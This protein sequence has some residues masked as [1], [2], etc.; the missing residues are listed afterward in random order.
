MDN[1]KIYLEI[2]HKFSFKNMNYLRND[3]ICGC[4]YCLE[5]F[6]PKEIKE[7]IEE[8]DGKETALCPY[9]GID[10]VIGKFSGFPITKQLLS[11]MNKRYFGRN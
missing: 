6:T 11:E 9:C 1:S 2:A 10:A 8:S 4:F 7:V 5:I 3:S